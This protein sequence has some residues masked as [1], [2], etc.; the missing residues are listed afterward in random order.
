[1]LCWLQDII[2]FICDSTSRKSFMLVEKCDLLD[3]KALLTS[4]SAV[5]SYSSPSLFSVVC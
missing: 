2:V 3:Q 1:M 5:Y 4:C